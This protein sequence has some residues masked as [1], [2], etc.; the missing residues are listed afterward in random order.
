MTVFILCLV[1][2]FFVYWIMMLKVE[3]IHLNKE[4]NRSKTILKTKLGSLYE[5]VKIEEARP[6]KGRAAEGSLLKIP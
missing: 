4:L 5:E 2:F 3:I 1:C 6:L